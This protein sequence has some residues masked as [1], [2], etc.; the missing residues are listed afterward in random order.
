MKTTVELVYF[1]MNNCPWCMRF[2]P[3]WNTLTENLDKFKFYSD[4][5][6]ELVSF[7]ASSKYAHGHPLMAE[8]IT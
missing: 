2:E 8:S 7:S 1:Y 4:C 5:I 3:S 6:K